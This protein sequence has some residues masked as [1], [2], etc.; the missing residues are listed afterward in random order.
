MIAMTFEQQAKLYE[1]VETAVAKKQAIV[2][3]PS[4]NPVLQVYGNTFTIPGLLWMDEQRNM[5]TPFLKME[6]RSKDDPCVPGLYVMGSRCPDGRSSG[7]VSMFKA[8]NRY[9]TII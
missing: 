7:N 1:M 4:L 5:Y 6:F 3:S 8:E 9:K 2:F